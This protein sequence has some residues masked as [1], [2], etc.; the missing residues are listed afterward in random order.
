MR[1]KNCVETEEF[2][3][4]Q[5]IDGALREWFHHGEDKYE[6][7]RKKMIEVANRAHIAY[8]CSELDLTYDDRVQKW[9]TTY[10][11]PKV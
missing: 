6:S 4:A 11:N 1:G 2:A 9:H 8:L 5:N 10:T 3:C 7:Q